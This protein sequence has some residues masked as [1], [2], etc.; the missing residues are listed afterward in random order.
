MHL[1]ILNQPIEVG[2]TVLVSRTGSNFPQ[3]H[4]V[5]TLGPVKVRLDDGVYKDPKTMVVITH[6]LNYARA[7]WP[8]WS[9]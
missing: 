9:I 2:D 3:L 1:D 4:K 7:T 8:E 5:K 6:Q